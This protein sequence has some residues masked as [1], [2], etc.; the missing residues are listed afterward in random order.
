MLAFV[1][2]VFLTFVVLMAALY[3]FWKMGSP[4]YWLERG[5]VIRL[6]EMVIEGE[7]RESDWDVF[8][9]MPIRHNPALAQVQERC[10]EIAETELVSGDGLQFTE[11]GIELLRRELEALRRAEEQA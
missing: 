10:I 2:T 5:N 1:V 7:A 4:V 9:G 8:V 3:G 11:R 6:L